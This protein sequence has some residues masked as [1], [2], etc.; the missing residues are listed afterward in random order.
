VQDTEDLSEEGQDKKGVD[1]VSPMVDGEVARIPFPKTSSPR[2]LENANFQKAIQA[3]EEQQINCSEIFNGRYFLLSTED[4]EKRKRW[5]LVDKGENKGWGSY[6][7]TYNAYEI[8]ENGE[9]N[10]QKL[11]NL[12]LISPQLTVVNAS[13]EV[14]FDEVSKDS[15]LL[16][17]EN[18][19][20]KLWYKNNFGDFKQV[21]GPQK[22][23]IE[24]E[25]RE[26]MKNSANGTIP[27]EN[28]N[29]IK[30]A[31]A[32]ND[33]NLYKE[34]SFM[35]NKTRFSTFAPK[36]IHGNNIGFIT[37]NFG[38][39]LAVPDS[40]ARHSKLHDK[41]AAL[42]FENRIRLIYEIFHCFNI[43]H[44]HTAATG[45]AIYHGDIKLQNI[46]FKIETNIDGSIKFHVSVIDYGFSHIIEDAADPDFVFSDEYLGCTEAYAAPEVKEAGEGG[47]K[48]DI[49]SLGK[50]IGRILEGVK[51]PSKFDIKMKSLM[52]HMLE[53]EVVSRPTIDEA[54]GTFHPI[55]KEVVEAEQICL[56]QQEKIDNVRMQ[57]DGQQEKDNARIAKLI[58]EN[59][60]ALE[61]Y[62]DDPNSNSDGIK[63]IAA[64]WKKR[65]PANLD[66]LETME[67]DD[68][69]LLHRKL[70]FI[71]FNI[72]TE[73]NTGFR[74][75]FSSLSIF[76]KGRGEREQMFY[77]YLSRKTKDSPF[78]PKS[79]P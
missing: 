8:K 35:A 29:K 3:L 48:S 77:D 65:L 53:D 22:K 68:L 6:G 4:I 9:C 36:V 13:E 39:P 54:L 23:E 52:K 56:K 66:E 58:E 14:N 16:I 46:L 10:L 28:R 5:F 74:K 27:E 12:K 2:S 49:Y 17:I 37:Q 79:S 60:S 73:R 20:W 43:I 55:Y 44:H 61:R 40:Q 21:T 34:A 1:D 7:K 62:A 33:S 45:K 72:A 30:L 70:N 47:I 24:Y 67:S 32:K 75:W 63:E 25:I 76:G 42:S 15:Y 26:A 57:I 69:M 38:E 31:L 78:A 18:N 50:V 11:Y 19:R 51:I 59:Y 41:I 71:A 64:A